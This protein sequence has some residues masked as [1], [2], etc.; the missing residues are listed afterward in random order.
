MKTSTI[1]LRMHIIQLLMTI[2]IKI[3]SYFLPS[4]NVYLRY[5]MRIHMNAL[6]TP[7]ATRRLKKNN[8][9]NVFLWVSQFLFRSMSL[10]FPSRKHSLQDLLLN[11]K[12]MAHLNKLLN[13]KCCVQQCVYKFLLCCCEMNRNE[14]GTWCL[15]KKCN[16]AYNIRFFCWFMLCRFKGNE[17]FII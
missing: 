11:K 2:V 14:I 16:Y 3:I 1:C 6:Q 15:K 13:T 8:I 4:S 17:F 10:S 9:T 12:S 7:P 5:H